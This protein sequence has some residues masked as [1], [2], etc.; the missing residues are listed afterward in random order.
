[1]SIRYF[2]DF[3]VGDRFTSAGLTSWLAKPTHRMTASVI[4]RIRDLLVIAISP[5]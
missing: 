5:D 2:E 4:Q 3:K 1:M